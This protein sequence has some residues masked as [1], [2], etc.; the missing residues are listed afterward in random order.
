MAINPK[1]PGIHHIAL[2]ASNYDRSKAFY[3]EQLGF[4]V[5]LEADNIFIFFAGS[6]AI[7]V[8]GP[9][10]TS[11]SNDV[12]NPYR[13]GL[14]HLALGCEDRDELERVAN[15]LQHHGIENTGIK[16][17]PTLGKEYISFK[18]PDRINWEFY[19]V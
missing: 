18:D 7:A 16:T 3:T 10:D 14:D 9:G 4:N 1:T 11:P 13:V 15:A 12:F 6:T 8:R 19:M 5:A 17:D 2:R